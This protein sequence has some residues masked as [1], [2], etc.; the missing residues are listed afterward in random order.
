MLYPPAP[1]LRVAALT[2]AAMALMVLLAGIARF[3]TEVERLP[4]TRRQS[5]SVGIL[6]LAAGA[7]AAGLGMGLGQGL[8]LLALLFLGLQLC[9]RF[10]SVR[11]PVLTALLAAAAAACGVEIATVAIGAVSVP[12]LPLAAASLAAVAVLARARIRADA[13]L[14]GEVRSPRRQDQARDLLLGLLVAVCALAN[15]AL[16]VDPAQIRPHGLIV[17]LLPFPF[18][19]LGLLRT[20][21]LAFLPR[22]R[23]SSRPSLS[24][25]VITV[26]VTGW[27]ATLLLGPLLPLGQ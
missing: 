24:D 15:L 19:L 11:A 4:S 5:W 7:A 16:L 26:A 13:G 23:R 25:P 22:H 1:S 3:W 18:L 27:T 2:M 12:W 21:H 10:W 14:P 20:S 17:A 8:P 6:P 9:G